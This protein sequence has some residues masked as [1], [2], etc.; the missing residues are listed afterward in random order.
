MPFDYPTWI[1]LLAA[2]VVS[3]VA[4][5]RARRRRAL[6][7]TTAVTLGV[8]VVAPALLIMLFVVGL[9]IFGMGHV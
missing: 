5:V 6:A 8:L 1:A 2:L 9:M 3:I 4:A 7:V